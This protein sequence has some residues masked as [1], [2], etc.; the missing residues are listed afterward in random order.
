MNYLVVFTMYNGFLVSLCLPQIVE[1]SSSAPRQLGA[2]FG[3]HGYTMTS[4]CP[5][6]AVLIPVS[7]GYTVLTFL[8]YNSRKF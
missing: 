4:T 6:N 3:S 7:H 2:Q 5:S 1:L 8:L